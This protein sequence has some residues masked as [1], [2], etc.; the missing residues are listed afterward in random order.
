METD[1]FLELHVPN[2]EKVIKFYSKLG[3]KV[4]WRSED[5]LVMKRGKSIL[6]F[7]SETTEVYNHSYFGKFSKKTKRGYA[8]EIIIPIDN[9]KKFYNKVKRFMKVV[10]PLKLKKWGRW[11]FRIEDPFGFYIRFT[12][13]YD[14]V[15]KLDRKQIELIKDYKKKKI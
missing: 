11:D 3:F 4:L 14:W 2:F 12:E 15:S 8:I 1:I 5:Y 6:N 9:I 13:R 10:E 7:Y